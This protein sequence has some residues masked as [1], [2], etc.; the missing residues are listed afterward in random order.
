MDVFG[1]FFLWIFCGALGAFL[2][3]CKQ[4]SPAGGFLLGFLLGPI[5]VIVCV[6]IPSNKRA[7]EENAL[8]KAA[9]DGEVKKCPF[10]AEYVKSEAQIC[11]YCN[12]S[13]VAQSAKPEPPRVSAKMMQPAVTT[14]PTPRQQVNQSDELLPLP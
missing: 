2:A 12:R 3:G 11:R 6:C 8:R 13:L 7:L 10:C 1:Y 14:V 4:N 9:K 5:G